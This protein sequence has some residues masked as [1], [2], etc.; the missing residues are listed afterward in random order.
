MQVLFIRGLVILFFSGKAPKGPKAPGP[1][2]QMDSGSLGRRPRRQ[3]AGG[4]GACGG[5]QAPASRH[6]DDGG[7]QEDVQQHLH[8]DTAHCPGAS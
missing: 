3:D 7:D 2:H 5:R 8:H 1:R 4:G 6:E